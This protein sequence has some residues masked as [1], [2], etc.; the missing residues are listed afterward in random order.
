MDP[1][2]SDDSAAAM[3]DQSMADNGVQIL[4]GSAPGM[5]TETDEGKA[6]LAGLADAAKSSLKAA[7]QTTAT[8]QTNE[9]D[10][11][12]QDSVTT[13]N[14]QQTL[15]T[16]VD[17]N[18]FVKLAKGE[19]TS[20]SI[21]F[22]DENGVPFTDQRG[23]A[24]LRRAQRAIVAGA[25][26]RGDSPQATLQAQKDFTA[27]FQAW[28]EGKGS[29]TPD[30][31]FGALDTALEGTPYQGMGDAA[32]GR[33]SMSW[34][35]SVGG[36]VEQQGY[37]QIAAI[38]PHLRLD[39]ETGFYDPLDKVNQTEINNVA[40]Q[41]TRSVFR[42][43]GT[44]SREN[45][46]VLPGVINRFR[47]VFE[48][49]VANRAIASALV[50]Q[51]ASELGYELDPEV[52]R[53]ST[54]I[55]ERELRGL[56]SAEDPIAMDNIHTTLDQL[57]KRRSGLIEIANT[58]TFVSDA[59]I[60]QEAKDIIFGSFGLETGTNDSGQPYARP[61]GAGQDTS[62]LPENWNPFN[63]IGGLDDSWLKPIQ[64][65]LSAGDLQSIIA[66]GQDARIWDTSDGTLR[67]LPEA[68]KD[69]AAARHQ[70][71]VA[72]RR[73]GLEIEF[74]T[75]QESGWFEFDDNLPLVGRS[76]EITSVRVQNAQQSWRML[77]DGR[78]VP[79]TT[80]IDAMGGASFQD[81]MARGMAFREDSWG[82]WWSDLGESYVATMAGGPLGY[83]AE[84]GE[85]IPALQGAKD[86]SRADIFEA[87]IEAQGI[88]RGRKADSVRK[89]MDKPVN[90]QILADHGR[91]ARNIM[92]SDTA[93]AERA[94]L[95][96]QIEASM[97]SLANAGVV[98]DEQEV[99]DLVAIQTQLR[100]GTIEPNGPLWQRTVE[101]A[102]AQGFNPSNPPMWA[103]KVAIMTMLVPDEA[104]A[105]ISG[106][107]F[108]DLDAERGYIPAAGPNSEMPANR[109][110]Y[111][112]SVRFR[113]DN[114]PDGS[115]F[116]TGT[117]DLPI[118]G[119]ATLRGI[120]LGDPRTLMAANKRIRP[121]AIMERG[122]PRFNV[123]NL[124]EEL[125]QQK[126]QEAND[127]MIPGRVTVG[128]KPT[129]QFN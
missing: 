1:T 98:L 50:G 76:T 72:M 15:K 103:T 69:P 121:S 94:V 6:K 11:E 61:R 21:D 95:A 57:L 24:F 54:N 128:G 108:M 25:L 49:D 122:L 2:L 14:D 97:E 81:D 116:Q 22:L 19:S 47:T 104:D 4:A 10:K 42:G 74:G 5:D 105:I 8:R 112:E 115:R 106:M 127:D 99:V 28:R 33:Y 110:G 78:F 90:R 85:L 80:P 107:H 45:L 87:N 31:L 12:I 77:P 117:F 100:S 114:M 48:P 92:M 9:A 125:A 29:L 40:E 64:D 43:D 66:V 55:I 118:M 119:A 67:L 124:R 60:S 82:E 51:V 38:L 75:S 101:V 52:L 79:D 102:K 44:V 83:M 113:F 26:M 23:D 35:A 126:A 41:M 18:P 17:R 73:A 20:E 89:W 96:N 68:Q 86:P 65:N 120:S 93:S 46:E 3:I 63:L 53:A 13:T 84:K 7:R 123:E 34:D 70:L 37:A 62:W 88:D 32:T 91:P 36:N 39:Q 56:E 71:A 27:K 59:N 111:T 30:L 16:I 129:N 109:R 58:P